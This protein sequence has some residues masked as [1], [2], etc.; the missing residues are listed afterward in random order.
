[1]T[2][3][4]AL[5]WRNL[6][7]NPRRT[8]LSAG[9]VAFMVFLL[10]FVLSMQ[11]G[12][13]DTMVNHGASVLHGHA[14]VQR[15]DYVDAPRVRF[16][17]ENAEALASEL[18][19]EPSIRAATARAMS[20]ALASNNDATFGAM[21]V[22]VEAQHESTVSWLPNAISSGRYL[23][24]ETNPA[25]G[26]SGALPEAVIGAGLARNL[27]IDLGD[28][29]V[30]LGVTPKDGM[31]ALVASVVGLV[32]S[33]QPALD[34]A[35]VHVAL[36]AFQDAFE[37][38]NAAHSVA[39]MYEDFTAA[40]VD[41]P[42]LAAAINKNLPSAE[43]SEGGAP[44]VALW[45]RL[46]PE[47][48]GAIDSDKASSGVLYAV[49]V[50]LVTFSIANTFVMMLHERTREFGT[51]LAMGAKPGTLRGTIHLETLLLAAIG[52][53]VGA[54]LG[55][56][57]TY[58][59]GQSGISLGSEAEDVLAQFQM[60]ERIFFG[61]AWLTLPATALLMISTTQIAAWFATR[62]VHSMQ[63][64]TAIREEM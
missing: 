54:L 21:V 43:D 16:V 34:R 57:T 18:R 27:G 11:Y 12:S 15:A 61:V 38:P 55:A 30:L 9:A 28:E 41:S 2:L 45:S 49:L 48:Q 22:G 39:V 40:N 58:Y 56:L 47:I 50:V 53:L 59:V 62:R 20:T 3:V 23:S 35:L 36:P 33:G 44:E 26:G 42:V 6:W 63:I 52:A 13:Y 10:I 7:R 5:A 29:L 17:L 64:V 51:L 31:A 14:Q 8:L 32:D 46:M 60:P 4:W 24:A 25:A 1:M 37:M 19:A